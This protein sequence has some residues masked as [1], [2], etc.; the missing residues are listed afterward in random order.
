MPR[1][2]DVRACRGVQV[3]GTRDRMAWGAR[4]AP[5]LLIKI[6]PDLTEL[7]KRDIAAVAMAC[8]VDGLI[9]SNT[10]IQRPGGAAARGLEGW[11]AIGARHRLRA[12]TRAPTL[13]NMPMPRRGE[14]AVPGCAR[15]GWAERAAPLQPQHGYA[16]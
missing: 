7:D 16:Q 5:P 4:G 12:R 15:G 11:A 14:R 3:K 6:A 10:T 8:H 9:V 13:W 2:R 1:S